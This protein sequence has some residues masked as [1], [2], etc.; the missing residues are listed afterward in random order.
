MLAAVALPVRSHAY[1]VSA[2]G[3]FAV[4]TIVDLVD[5]RYRRSGDVA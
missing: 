4:T 2:T 5:W 3:C 1:L